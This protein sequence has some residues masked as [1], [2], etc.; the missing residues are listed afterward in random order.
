MI[1]GWLKIYMSTFYKDDHFRAWPGN[2]PSIGLK[3]D[4]CTRI[5]S[6]H[7]VLS[8]EWW[9]RVFIVVSYINNVQN[10]FLHWRT[11]IS[12]HHLLIPPTF[13]LDAPEPSSSKLSQSL[14][15]SCSVSRKNPIVRPDLPHKPCVNSRQNFWRTKPYTPNQ[16]KNHE[17][18]P[19]PKLYLFANVSK[20]LGMS[21]YFWVFPSINLKIIV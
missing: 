8:Q 20:S 13:G 12:L 15:H 7:D 6:G 17:S 3:M 21:K 14:R 9:L 10:L 4:S 18:E 2:P 1:D 5:K 11:I 19:N 16:W